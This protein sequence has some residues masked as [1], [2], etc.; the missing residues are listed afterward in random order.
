MLLRGPDR[1]ATAIS[2]TV[3]SAVAAILLLAEEYA[4]VCAIRLHLLDRKVILPATVNSH[5]ARQLSY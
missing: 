3:V 1:S 4:C 2:C 5:Q